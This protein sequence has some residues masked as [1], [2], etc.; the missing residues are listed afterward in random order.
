MK[1]VTDMIMV[2][3]EVEYETTHWLSIGTLT[4]NLGCP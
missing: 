2:S 1:K 3:T 4:F